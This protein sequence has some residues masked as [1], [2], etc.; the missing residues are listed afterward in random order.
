MSVRISFF[1]TDKSQQMA[2]KSHWKN[3]D[4]AMLTSWQ[5]RIP[6]VHQFNSGV[7]IGKVSNQSRGSFSD[8]GIVYK[9]KIIIMDFMYYAYF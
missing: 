4:I 5:K 3:A 7:E 8:V 2:Q 1:H 9:Y 6:R